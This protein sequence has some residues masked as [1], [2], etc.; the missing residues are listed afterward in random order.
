MSNDDPRDQMESPPP[1]GVRMLGLDNLEDHETFGNH[2]GDAQMVMYAIPRAVL[3]G[4]D[5]MVEGVITAGAW[6]KQAGQLKGRLYISFDG[7]EHDPREMFE[8]PEAVSFLQGLLLTDPAVVLPCMV[9]DW[10]DLAHNPEEPLLATGQLFAIYTAFSKELVVPGT[11]Q[12][13]VGKAAEFRD[14]L[15]RGILPPPLKVYRKR[16]AKRCRKVLGA[17]PPGHQGAAQW[18][19]R[20]NVDDAFKG[21]HFGSGRNKLIN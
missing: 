1:E 9:E 19:R 10:P 16:L 2:L 13:N 6:A 3:E 12:Y 4:S 8:V 21:G 14:L 11:H 15:M 18:A 20:M 5:P 7:W 17:K